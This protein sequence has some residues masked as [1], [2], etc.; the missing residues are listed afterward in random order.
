MP[1]H[2]KHMHHVPRY[3][4]ARKYR[5]RRSDLIIVSGRL[6]AKRRGLTFTNVLR[7]S[8][9]KGVCLT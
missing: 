6:T 1:N 5:L 8:C 9:E 4:D 7:D 3:P 2:K